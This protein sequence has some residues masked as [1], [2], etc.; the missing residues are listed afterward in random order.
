[1]NIICLFVVATFTVVG[2]NKYK[3]QQRLDQLLSKRLVM[4]HVLK[5]KIYSLPNLREKS[6]GVIVED[7]E[8]I[9]AEV[10]SYHWHGDAVIIVMALTE[11]S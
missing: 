6:G 11:R 10:S 2:T 3:A 1:M 7:S 9:A 5:A 8:L 4:Y